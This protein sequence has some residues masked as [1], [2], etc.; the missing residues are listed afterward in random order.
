[1][2]TLTKLPPRFLEYY[3]N[4]R[5]WKT[6][7]DFF[8]T[9]VVFLNRL[10]EEHFLQLIAEDRILKLK[11]LGNKLAVLMKEK[12]QIKEV[13]DFQLKEIELLAEG[14]LKEKTAMLE[15]KQAHLEYQMID[16]IHEYREV[17]R[18][19]YVFMEVVLDE[20]RLLIN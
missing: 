19:L 13:L 17:K 11:Q 14:L 12:H 15:G 9:E 7:L 6:E 5:R 8:N 1:M 4:V 20:R 3:I 18:E 16:L 10:M 2:E